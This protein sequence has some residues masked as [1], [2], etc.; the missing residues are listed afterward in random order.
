[1]IRRKMR[2]VKRAWNEIRSKFEVV[3]IEGAGSPAEINLRSQDIV[4]MRT[5]KMADAPVILV[6]DIDRGGAFASLMGTFA[7]LLPSERRYIKTFLLNK[8]RGDPS[9]LGNAMDEITKRTGVP[10]LGVI[11]YKHDLSIQEEDAVPSRVQGSPRP[12]VR[13]GVIY[14]QHISNFTDLDPLAWEPDVQLIYVMEPVEVTGLDAII[15][16]G[17]KNTSEDLIR[18]YESGL[19]EAIKHA[20]IRGTPVVGICGGYQ[21]LGMSIDDK[22]QTESDKKHLPGLGLLPVKTFFQGKKVL[23]QAVLS[24]SGAHPFLTDKSLKLNGYE[25]HH[26][27]TL[28]LKGA[29]TAFISADKAEGCVNAD[30]KVFGCYL[31]DLFE[32]D[33]FRRNFVN[34]LRKLKNLSPLEAPLV[35]VVAH[36]EKG[37]D[38]L[39]D[40]V[41]DNINTNLLDK[42]VGLESAS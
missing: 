21:M 17:T 28:P 19:A 10:F 38:E 37:F 30:G 4:N 39:A 22:Q 2:P 33:L 8:F 20:A 26:G 24:P 27:R 40:M 32:N 3:I 25:I 31:H 15:L 14:L 41:L 11:P 5:A 23:G 35:N 34:I 1:M 6:A 13:I 12:E 29:R 9:L 16:P 42:L 36:R 18:L 7:L